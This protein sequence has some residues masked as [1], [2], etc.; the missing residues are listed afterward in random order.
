MAAAGD[1]HRRAA[2]AQ[3]AA[4]AIIAAI[5]AHPTSASVSCAA[6]DALVELAACADVR[7]A[8]LD[9]VDSALAASGAATGTTGG[10]AAQEVLQRVRQRVAA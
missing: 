10:M 1:A 6:G 9:A 3:G 8:I 5:K 2:A 7:A 4:P